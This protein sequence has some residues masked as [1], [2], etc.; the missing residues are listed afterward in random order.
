[1]STRAH[2]LTPLLLAA[3]LPIVWLPAQSAPRA[4]AAALIDAA[5]E[6]RDDADATAQMLLRAAAANAE[7][8][9]AAILIG[10]VQGRLQQL[11]QPAALLPQIDA[12]D[13]DRVHGVLAQRLR[14]LRF[15]LLRAKGSDGA[16]RQLP[17]PPQ[18][19]QDPWQDW[20]AD[21]LVIGP[22]GDSGDSY[23]D[24]PFPPEL[25]FPARD[26]SLAGR[27]GPVQPHVV[28]RRPF[29]RRVELEAKALPRQGCY[30]ALCRANVDG[31][32][33]GFA[34]VESDGSLQLFANGREVGR[35]VP[36]LE[37]GPQLRR[38]A[39]QLPKGQNQL[40]LKTGTNGRAAVSLRLCDGRGRALKGVHLL[41][42]E[43]PLQPPPAAVAAAGAAF[44]DGLATLQQ[45][46]AAADGDD[47][48]L[49]LVAQLLQAARI[50][51]T[52]V[53][54]AAAMALLQQPPA[55]PAAA[56]AL[57]QA[58][59][60][61]TL[62]PEELRLQKARELE[63]R[64]LQALP[65]GHHRAM[66]AR[67]RQLAIEDKREEALRLLRQAMTQHTA[68]P[69]TYALAFDLV[70]K[71]EFNA[72]VEPLLQQWQQELPHDVRPREELARRQQ[73]DGAP[74]AAL[75]E[76]CAALRAR[77]DS[78]G[79]A[80]AAAGIAADLGDFD[81][82]RR[83]RDLADP[84]AAATTPPSLS[85]LTE[86]AGIARRSGDEAAQ[87]QLLDQIM[88]HPDVDADTLEHA[89]D[90]WLQL[91]D[92][93]KA[94]AAW[95]Q[96]LQLDPARHALR[97]GI[98][99]LAD[100]AR[101]GADLLPFRRDGDAA[102]AAFHKTEREDGATTTLLID[103]MLVEML[104]DGSRVE[105]VHQLRRINDLQGV[106]AMKQPAELARA[107]E[108]LL[109]RTVANGQSFVPSKT[110]RAFAMVRLEPGAF[111][112]WRYRNYQPAPDA[113]PWRSPEFRFGSDTE[114][115]LLT[116]Y[117]LILP[118]QAHGDL[119][120]RGFSAPTETKTLAD[121]RRAL[122][123]R[124]EN[125]PRLPEERNAPPL[126]DLVGVAQFGEDADPAAFARQ[127]RMSLQLQT[128]P[129]PVVE[130]QAAALTKDIQDRRQAMVAIHDWVQREIATGPD[131]GPTA[132]ILR[133][134]GQ[135]LLVETSLLRAAGFAVDYA[136]T[137]PVRDA[138]SADPRPLF[139]TDDQWPLP[140]VRLTGA[141]EP[142]WL[143]A[144]APRYLPLGLVP[145][146]R[147]GAEAL[148]ATPT[149]AAIVRVPATDIDVA[150]TVAARGDARLD[151]GGNVTFEGDILFQDQAGYA[152][153]EQLREL[154]AD[155]RKLAARQL[156]QRFFRE[157]R[158]TGAALVDIEPPGQLPKVHCS[159][160]RALLQRD[161]ER[162]LLPL[163][164]PPSRLL[165]AFGDRPGRQLP[166]RLTNEVQ[167]D[168]DVT[169]DPGDELAL[170]Q[171]P[172]PVLI[173]HGPLTF[174]LT[175]TLQDGKVHIVEHAVV[176]AGTIAQTGFGEWMQA[177]QKVEAAETANLVLVAK[178][179]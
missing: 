31:E 148:L 27:F 177:L 120:M 125:V 23:I 70:Q 46:A 45:A 58:L 60:T 66:V 160:E 85:Y 10:V 179:K 97:D 154:K 55:Q 131:N 56:L 68:G 139:S 141:G 39:V 133:K 96:S 149:A 78:S 44:Q 20:A 121:G 29:Q 16:G 79:I 18:D 53:E 4:I 86:L 150:Q 47:R 163:P 174:A 14:E 111:V 170:A 21:F 5:A 82:A 51:S 94:L 62:L 102:I 127:V 152:L 161:G 173:Q 115:Y 103:Q 130:Q 119:R 142:V 19:L 38:F 73:R 172:P 90:R 101:C 36:W 122:V 176:R 109:V 43:T 28:A 92:T 74:A 155:V 52:H 175:C 7:S 61:L 145:G 107:D 71:L 128:R 153:A 116:E 169:L 63:D 159:F 136:V 48:A 140:G 126:T 147:A 30:Y 162:F 157:W 158:L 40:L 65:A 72:E 49:L 8:P 80:N 134:K 132:T 124:R 166:L 95:R 9:A 117:V 91:G 99:R 135:R 42:A 75:A 178:P 112:E 32:I 67:V 108:V 17:A 168:W 156:S 37:P 1:M 41:P 69:E 26:A 76:L 165:T 64:A 100:T 164:L 98:A 138:L 89:G 34:E 105:E 93:D 77:P 83:C 171:L 87:R 123:F 11:Q 106:E 88:A 118:P 104:A 25:H 35:I 114:P 113:E 54:L 50:G 137:E 144:D 24:V 57:G 33:S 59:R 167:I 13:L 146:S 6:A 15:Q 2:R 3:L 151:A 12:I 143:F 110:D 84:F 22:F 129:T 81:T